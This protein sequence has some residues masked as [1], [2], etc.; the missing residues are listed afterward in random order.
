MRPADRNDSVPCKHRDS[1]KIARSNDSK[2]R[3]RLAKLL[4]F[5]PL[6][7]GFAGC[8]DLDESPV[9]AITPDQF[10][11]NEQEVL[12]GLASVYAELRGTMWAYYNLSEVS[13]DEMV[14]PTRGQDWFDNGR[15]IEIHEQGWTPNSTSA[16]DDI[17]GMWNNLF[18]G[19]ARA[20]VVLDALTR[21]TVPNQTAVEAEL[22]T[23][24]AF[25]YYMLQDM[26]GGVPIVTDTEVMPRERNTRAE[27]FNFVESELLAARD[28][29]PLTWPAD[30]HG[31]FT[32]G[33]ANAILASL[34]VNAEVFSGSVTVAGLQR[35]T[36]RWDD[37]VSAA[38][39]VLN[40]GAY[41]L[42]TEWTDN[43]AP[44]NSGSPENILVVK[45]A[46]EAG[47]GLTIV[48]RGL[49]YNSL[50]SGPWNGFAT[51][52]ETYFAFDGDDQRTSIFMVGPQVNL[53]TGEPITD[54]AGVPLVFTPDIGDITQAGEEEGVRIVKWAPDPDAVGGDNG[55][56]MAY[57]R[58][59]EM[60]LI[61]AEART[62]ILNER[63]FELTAEAKRRQDLI[64][65]DRFSAPWAFKAATDPYR[66]LMPIP[67]T[68]LDTNPLLAQNPGY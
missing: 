3:G 62:V 57:F 41:T 34:Y 31:R 23:L 10:Y 27:V 48:M 18:T 9:S 61:K 58:L 13:T 38:D 53:L 32:R 6:L 21:I 36:P 66:M 67:Q 19:V 42:A 4:L 49:H 29:L 59:A 11:Q 65:H 16:L 14:V 55:N 56:D 40:S 2:G 43:F 45:H 68:Q 35:G 50:P 52:A 22:R 1:M 30:Q 64:R 46:A 51:L 25:Y 8:T 33:A 39:A 47:L 12:G 54:R 17:N 26:F 7:A 60:Y 44:E 5:L 15:W 20:N 28:A 63:L 37:A 24:R